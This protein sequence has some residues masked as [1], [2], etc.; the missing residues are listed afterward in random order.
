[1]NRSRLIEGGDIALLVSHKT[2][3]NLD[4]VGQTTNRGSG[5]GQKSAVL[6]ADSRCGDSPTV[7]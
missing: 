1:M 4:G 5:V 7:R 2:A 3:A 6:T